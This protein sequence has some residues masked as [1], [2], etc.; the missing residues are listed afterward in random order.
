MRACLI[1]QCQPHL[2]ATPCSDSSTQA[3]CSRTYSLKMPTALCN[4]TL[5]RDQ[6]ASPKRPHDSSTLTQHP[7]SGTSMPAPKQTHAHTLAQKHLI[8]L[9][10]WNA[11][12]VQKHFS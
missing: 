9:L 1:P 2:T 6:Q 10:M 5:Q 4:G 7:G 3:S 8:E 11:S 12:Y